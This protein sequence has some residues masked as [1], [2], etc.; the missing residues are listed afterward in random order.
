MKKNSRTSDIVV[1]KGSCEAS[2]DRGT[3]QRRHQLDLSERLANQRLAIQI[4][5]RLRLDVAQPFSYIGPENA[6][7]GS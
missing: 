7:E 6:S 5:V 4:S 2:S 3:P 1:R